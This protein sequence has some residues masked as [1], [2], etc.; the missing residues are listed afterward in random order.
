MRFQTKTTTTI[1]CVKH[2]IYKKSRTRVVN[3]L[4][5]F[6]CVQQ[7]FRFSLEQG[8]YECTFKLE[9]PMRVQEQDC[10]VRLFVDKK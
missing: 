1:I 2:Y 3:T 8:R 7:V 4:Q 10:C 5:N 9:T 6:S